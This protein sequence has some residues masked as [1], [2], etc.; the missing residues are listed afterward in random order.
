[1]TASYAI[2][3]VTPPISAGVQWTTTAR[4]VVT[5]PIWI[6]ASQTARPSLRSCPPPTLECLSTMRRSFVSLAILSA[7]EAALEGR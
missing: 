4:A 3:S 6:A 2:L 1:M 7:W 5:T